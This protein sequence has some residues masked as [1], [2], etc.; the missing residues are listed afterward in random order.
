MNPSRMI[1]AALIALWFC[2]LENVRALALAAYWSPAGKLFLPRVAFNLQQNYPDLK[3]FRDSLAARNPGQEWEII[4]QSLY[5]FQIY[6]TAG[7]AAFNF[8]ATGIGSGLSASPGNANGAKVLADTN[9]TQAGVLPSPMMFYA[10]SIEIDFQPGSV[11]TAN[12][13]TPQP[14]GSSAAA[15][16]AG[17]GVVQIGAANDVAAVYKAGAL[18]FV[19]GQKAYLEEAPLLRFPPKCRLE[20]DVA[21]GGNSATTANFAIAV[22]RSGGRPYQLDPGIGIFSMQNFVVNLQFP[23]VVA[24]PSGF[25]GRIGC[26]LDGWLFRAVQ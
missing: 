19:I 26:I 23:V 10:Q 4:K 24:T 3:S 12:T 20:A 11:N 22:L 16:A 9:M 13:F 1:A 14:P 18:R 5:D 15:P 25:N 17:T 2:V 7:A 6:P 8:F 21:V